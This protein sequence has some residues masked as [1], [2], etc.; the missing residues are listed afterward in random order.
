[1][2]KNLTAGSVFKALITFAVPYL[3]S[4]FLQTLYSLADILIVGRFN[5]AEIIT[6]VSVGGQIMHMIT[7]VLVGLAVG[8]TVLIGQ[9]VGERNDGKKKLLIGN[10]AVLFLALAIL[11]SVLMVFLRSAVISVMSTPAE[12]VAAVDRYLLICSLGIPFIMAYNIICSVYRGLG[13]SQSPMY[14]IAVAC[15]VNI[16]LDLIFVGGLKMGA[17][18]A[19]LATVIAQAVSVIIALIFISR[20]GFGFALGKADFKPRFAVMGSILKIGVPVSFQDFVIQVSFLIILIIANRR[21]VEAAAA[22]GIVERLIG[23]LFLIPSAMLASVSAVSAQSVGAELHGRGL[24]SLKIGIAFVVVVGVAACILFQFVSAFAVSLFTTDPLVVIYGEQYLKAYV[25][26]CF[27][28]GVHFCFSGWF[29]AYGLSWVSFLHNTL[30]AFLVRIPGSYLA[31][32]CFPDTL[33]PMGLACPGG[34]LLSILICV[35]AFSL[36]RKKRGGR[37]V[38]CPADSQ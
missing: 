33:Y 22:V 24:Q 37:F 35:I 31:S 34:S 26:D 10:T 6:A 32:V 17:P 23:I 8:S 38:D 36:F 27:L 18:G 5:G 30:S 4:C 14:F 1:M 11:L 29:C 15:V 9:A 19:A 16:V 3:I 13:D 28:A 21:G 20:K 7:V 2:E 12:S 25:I